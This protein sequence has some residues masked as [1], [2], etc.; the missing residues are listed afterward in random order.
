MHVCVQMIHGVSN[1][2]IRDMD[3][4]SI[5]FASGLPDQHQ[6]NALQSP[7]PAQQTEK[8]KGS[9]RRRDIPLR[10]QAPFID[11]ELPAAIHAQ[12]D[13]SVQGSKRAGKFT[14]YFTVGLDAEAAYRCAVSPTHLTLSSLQLHTAH[15][16][17]VGMRAC[18]QKG[19]LY[20]GAIVLQ[21]AVCCKQYNSKQAGIHRVCN[22]HTFQV[23]MSV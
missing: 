16:A 19:I 12:H 23:C 21:H 13:S 1:A 17:Q 22:M 4:W 14:Y 2:T 18:K 15:A 8:D 9:K 6:Q 10:D 5:S 11:D 7:N 3:L 20:A